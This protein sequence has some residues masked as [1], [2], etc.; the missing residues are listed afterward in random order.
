MQKEKMQNNFYNWKKD[1][2]CLQ[3]IKYSNVNSRV[4]RK[5]VTPYCES[6]QS[7]IWHSIVSHPKLMR[8]KTKW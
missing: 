6:F 2:L 4:N 8:N 5:L 7:V 3:K 1:R